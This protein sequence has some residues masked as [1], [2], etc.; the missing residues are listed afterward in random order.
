MKIHEKRRWHTS[1]AAIVRRSYDLGLIGAAEYRRHCQYISFK[2]WTKGEPAEPNFQDPELL[3]NAL[4]ALG[5]KID[6]TVNTFCSDLH[7]EPQTFK[8]VT[9]VDVPPIQT[10]KAEVIAMEMGLIGSKRG[11][12]SG[13]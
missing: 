3:P 7:F 13:C 4:E 2:G 10:T 12:T 5:K 6:L 1:V 9:G 8:E 11:A